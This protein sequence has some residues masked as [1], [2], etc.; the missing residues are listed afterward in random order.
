D[1]RR[2]AEK[3][4]RERAADVTAAML[5]LQEAMDRAILAGLIVEPSFQAVGNRF[6]TVGVSAESYLVKA[7]IMRR[8][9]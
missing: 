8:L 7:K 5:D 9:S 4:D 1:A 3:S 6:A 2:P